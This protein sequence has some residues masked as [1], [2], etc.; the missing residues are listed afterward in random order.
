MR[1]W[2]AYQA[3]NWIDSSPWNATVPLV[4]L[5]L[6]SAPY[7]ENTCI[8]TAQFTR[9]HDRPMFQ[10]SCCYHDLTKE[11]ETKTKT[12][13]SDLIIE[14]KTLASALEAKSPTPI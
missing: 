12:T 9:N 13:V 1:R 2:P 4:V 14:I 10:L 11:L 8:L 3:T 7:D 5:Q 6:G